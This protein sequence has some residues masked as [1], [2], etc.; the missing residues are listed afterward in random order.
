LKAKTSTTRGTS[1]S[2]VGSTRSLPTTTGAQVYTATSRSLRCKRPPGPDTSL[3]TTLLQDPAL[4]TTNG[5]RA[6]QSIRGL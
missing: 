4:T 3:W 5:S 1:T 6:A 2:S